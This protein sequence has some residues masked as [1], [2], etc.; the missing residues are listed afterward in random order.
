MFEIGLVTL[1][2]LSIGFLLGWFA[3]RLWKHYWANRLVRRWLDGDPD[4]D[5]RVTEAGKRFLAAR[6]KIKETRDVKSGTG[7][8]GVLINRFEGLLN[9]SGEE[10]E[11]VAELLDSVG[12]DFGRKYIMRTVAPAWVVKKTLERLR[13]RVEV[14]I[15]VK[16]ESD[17]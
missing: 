5:F 3:G 11:R 15:S 14:A 12:M 8:V 17:G 16:G 10:A 7:N 6:Q 1:L 9:A 13:Q 4:V 2:D